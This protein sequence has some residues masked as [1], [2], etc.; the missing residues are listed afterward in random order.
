MSVTLIGSVIRALGGY[1]Q[2]DLCN[3]HKYT[4]TLFIWLIFFYKYIKYIQL[5]FIFKGSYCFTNETN[6]P[7]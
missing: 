5:L 4:Y 3:D 1:T 7:I 2:R 6:K